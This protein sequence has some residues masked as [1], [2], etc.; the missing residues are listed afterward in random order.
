MLAN[1]ICRQLY[2]AVTCVRQVGT[3]RSS[4]T[5]AAQYKD[6][7]Y[8]TS[9]PDA[10]GRTHLHR[11]LCSQV[12]AR[13]SGSCTGTPLAT[14]PSRGGLGRSRR[15]ACPACGT[16]AARVCARCPPERCLLAQSAA[17]ADHPLPV[18]LQFSC[19]STGT[20]PDCANE[21]GER[22]LALLRTAAIQLFVRTGSCVSQQCRKACA[23]WARHRCTCLDG[24]ITM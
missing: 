15:L 9:G 12:A 24:T 16:L 7:P 5:A 23:C 20:K 13:A 8:T 18:A 6:S 17:R 19:R 2:C 14:S 11:M 22:A 1:F 3:R 21:R 4:I 10:A